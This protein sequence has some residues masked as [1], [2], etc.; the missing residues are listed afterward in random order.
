[1]DGEAD[2]MRRV[3]SPDPCERL[4]WTAIPS[5]SAVEAFSCVPY[6]WTEDESWI[7]RIVLDK[8]RL[9]GETNTRLLRQLESGRTPDVQD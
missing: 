1:M 7:S 6:Q 8:S 4:D 9:H 3:V 5:Q 2:S